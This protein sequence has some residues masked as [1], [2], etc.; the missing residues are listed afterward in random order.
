M[1]ACGGTNTK[2]TPTRPRRRPLAARVRRRGYRI[3]VLSFSDVLSLFGKT[4]LRVA[5]K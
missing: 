5:S 2:T 1:P 4:R 3:I